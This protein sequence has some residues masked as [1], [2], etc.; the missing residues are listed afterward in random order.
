MAIEIERKYLVKSP[1]LHLA[2]KRLHIKQGYIVNDQKQVIRIREKGD[3]YFLTIKGNQI[4]ISRL[5]YDF[6]I[7]KKD[8]NELISNF[9][10]DTI[11][12]KTRHYLRFKDHIWEIDEFHKKNQGLV[13]AEIELNSENEN[14]EL[15][16][17]VEKEVTSEKKYYN[18]NLAT[19]PYN[20]W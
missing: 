3:E 1:P 15:P 18:M 16:S 5:E 13:V 12:E 14:F 17:W 11:I 2:E 10:R 6:P 8:A 9:C 4:G 7:S 20:N 19:N